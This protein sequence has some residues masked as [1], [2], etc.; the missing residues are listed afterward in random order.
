M[1]SSTFGQLVTFASQLDPDQKYTQY[2]YVRAQKGDTIKK[3][4]GRR[5]HPELVATILGLNKRVRLANGHYLRSA[6]Q[7]LKTNQLVRIPGTLSNQDSFSVLCGDERPIVKDGYALYDTVDRRGRVGLN[8]FLGYHP[9]EIDISVQ[10]ENYAD[11]SAGASLEAQI[12]MLERMAGRGAYGGA[13][14]GPPA[15]VRVSITDNSGNIVPLIPLNYQW[16]PK[17]PA[18]PLYRIGAIA[19]GAGALS[20]PQGRRVRQSAVVTIKQYT[21]LTV[22]K[23]S[24]TQRARA[25]STHN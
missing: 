9:I 1:P 3:I 15:V 11:G 23:R 25:K 14:D 22:V 10:F 24:A 2:V 18:A 7:V 4:A 13:A 19:W 21:P 5:G 20:D 16:S 17:N 6:T 8:R 12:A